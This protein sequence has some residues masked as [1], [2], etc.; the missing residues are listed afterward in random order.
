MAA[1]TTCPSCGSAFL[2][3]LRREDK[4]ADEVLVELRCSECLTWMQAPH[5]KAD[6][7]ELDRL[8]AEFRAAILAEY[9][10]SVAASME[11]LAAC[12]GPALALDLVGADDFAP[13]ARGRAT[14][15][16]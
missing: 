12:L 11:A 16:S 13:R 10:R 4:G 7:N 5:T 8:Q 9:E 3:P 6:A 1:L 2:Q 15:R 14:T